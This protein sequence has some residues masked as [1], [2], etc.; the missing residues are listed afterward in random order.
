MKVYK[1]GK[2]VKNAKVLYYGNGT[3]YVVE[4]DGTNYDPSAFE[5]K[6]STDQKKTKPAGTKNKAI[7]KEDEVLTSGDKPKEQGK[8]IL[9]KLKRK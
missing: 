3:P 4:I 2:E 6:D 1:D 5:F 9:S 7:E 8:G